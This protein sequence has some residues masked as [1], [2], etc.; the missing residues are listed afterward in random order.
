MN[1]L[2]ASTM[3]GFKSALVRI[4]H[5]IGSKFFDVFRKVRAILYFHYK[6]ALI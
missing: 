6:S 1:I 2:Q 5:F 4:W 3:N